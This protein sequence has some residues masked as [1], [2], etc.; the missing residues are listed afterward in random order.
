[1]TTGET[2]AGRQPIDEPAQRECEHVEVQP[3]P[4]RRALAAH[5]A[6]LLGDRGAPHRGG[7]ADP[8]DERAA[9]RKRDASKHGHR[10]TADRQPHPAAD[11]RAVGGKRDCGAEHSGHH[12][13]HA[14]LRDCDC[15]QLAPGGAAGTQQS[16][17]TPVAVDGPERRQVGE[18]QRDDRA[19][20]CQHH[21]QG[22]GVQRVA[23]RGV[24]LV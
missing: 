19:R 17:V 18:A 1:L 6:A 13:D 16:E 11:H 21:V 23:R 12:P 10:A 8:G 20:H 22:L 2:R 14:A 15:E 9:D 24:E 5:A 3:L 7:S 4:K